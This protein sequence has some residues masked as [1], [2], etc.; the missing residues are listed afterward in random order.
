MRAYALTAPNRKPEVI[1]SPVPTVADGEVLVRVSASSANPHDVTVASGAAARYMTYYYPAILGSDLAGTVEAVG[2]GVDDLAPGDRVFGLVR[3]RVVARGSFAELVAVPRE[4][5]ARTPHGIEDADA[6]VLGLA[7]LTAL[8]A[9]D[10][11][12]PVAGDIVLVNGA[13]GGVGSYALQMLVARGATVVATARPDEEDHVKRLGAKD[14]VDWEADDVAAAVQAL[15]PR[16]IAAI[17]DLVTRD[18]GAFTAL[19]AGVLAPGGRVACTGHAADPDQLPGVRAVNVVAEVDQDAL[20]VVADLAGSGVLTTSIA[21]TYDFDELD[22]AFSALGRGVV[23]KL[24]V[25]I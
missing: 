17:V 16:G 20:L 4:W 13:T 1:D 10:A 2:P 7:A 12:A 5:V 3:E 15:H 23:G 9:V 18:S 24:A 6:G 11:I 25:R 22:E 21:H 8:R 19:A 14:V